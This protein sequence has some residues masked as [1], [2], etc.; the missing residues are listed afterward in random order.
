MDEAAKMGRKKDSNEGKGSDESKKDREN[1][2]SDPTSSDERSS[3]SLV[4]ILVGTL[5]GH[6]LSF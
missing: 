6:M 2:L 4:I 5:L 3:E 1:K